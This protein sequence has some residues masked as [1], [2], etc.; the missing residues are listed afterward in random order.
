MNHPNGT[1]PLPWPKRK[2]CRITKNHFTS[3]VIGSSISYM[4]KK[5]LII[6]Y[7][8]GNLR[9]VQKAFERVGASAFLQD[10]PKRL[11]EFDALVLPGVGAFGE[12]M[13]H[14]QRGGWVPVIRKW[15]QS[16]KPFLGIR[17]SIRSESLESVI[18][19]GCRLPSGPGSACLFV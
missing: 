7:G 6:D 3:D 19:W 2:G 10:Q 13:R 16:G 4:K 5:I 1:Q 14:L 18:G 11:E 17:K 15:I 12:C 9:S 8:M